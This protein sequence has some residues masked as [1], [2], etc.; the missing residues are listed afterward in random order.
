MYDPTGMVDGT[1][2][3]TVPADSAPAG[4][5]GTDRVPESSVSFALLTASNDR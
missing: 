3:D 2:T 5:V 4:S 1:V